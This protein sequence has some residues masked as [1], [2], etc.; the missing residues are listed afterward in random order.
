MNNKTFKRV[1]GAQA[2]IVVLMLVAY[3]VNF[4]KFIENDFEA[5]YKSEIVNGIGVFMPPA[6]VITV[7]F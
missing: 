6:A 1:F 7:W 4:V 5:P 2:V 3:V